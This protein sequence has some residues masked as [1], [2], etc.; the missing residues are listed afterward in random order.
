M[1]IASEGPCVQPRIAGVGIIIQNAANTGLRTAAIE[2][3]CFSMAFSSE[4]QKEGCEP[5][6]RKENLLIRV[7]REGYFIPLSG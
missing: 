5:S 7:N 2:N 3:A 1:R 4:D 6:W